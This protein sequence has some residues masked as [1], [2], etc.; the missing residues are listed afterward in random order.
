M[1]EA[2]MCRSG[3]HPIRSSRDR[4]ANGGCAHCA[5]LNER[6]YRVRCRDALR[7]MQALADQA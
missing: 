4:R 5:R 7:T 2:T 3:R 1:P 6:A